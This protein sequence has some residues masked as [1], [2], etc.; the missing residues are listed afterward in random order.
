[1][2]AMIDA[3]VTDFDGVVLNSMTP[4]QPNTEALGELT[5][6]YADVIHSFHAEPIQYDDPIH[7]LQLLLLARDMA[8]CRNNTKAYPDEDAVQAR[9]ASLQPAIEDAYVDY[10][11]KIAHRPSLAIS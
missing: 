4:D 11:R 5:L 7:C 6:K 10:L 1:M 3:F 8:K 2:A 9:L